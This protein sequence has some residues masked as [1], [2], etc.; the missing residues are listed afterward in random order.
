MTK[1]ELRKAAVAK[2]N[3]EYELRERER[4]MNIEKVLTDIRQSNHAPELPYPQNMSI[5]RFLRDYAGICAD[6]RNRFF[7]PMQK[8]VVIGTEVHLP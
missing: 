3:E 8:I 7:D 1:K 2:H 4:Q 5:R 6:S